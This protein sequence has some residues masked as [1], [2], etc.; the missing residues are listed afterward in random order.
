[1]NHIQ[2]TGQLSL[3]Q[4][5]LSDAEEIFQVIDSQREYLG[6]WLPF[7]GATHSGRWG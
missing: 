6:R 3:H 7:V 1:M 2:V 5:A 4:I